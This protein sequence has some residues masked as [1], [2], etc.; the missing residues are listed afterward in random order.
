MWEKE[1]EDWDEEA[2][3]DFEDKRKESERE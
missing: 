3:I 1:E 2:R